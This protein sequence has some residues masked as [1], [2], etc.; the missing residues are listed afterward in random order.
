MGSSSLV[1]SRVFDGGAGEDSGGIEE[2]SRDIG[3]RFFDGDDDSD[4]GGDDEVKS[5]VRRGDNEVIVVVMLSSLDPCCCSWA[6]S[7]V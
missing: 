5:I 3:D 4:I 7:C 1:M 2:R 6:L